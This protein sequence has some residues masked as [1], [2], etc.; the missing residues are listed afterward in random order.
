MYIPHQFR[1]E[2]I[3][4][5]KNFIEQ[6]SFGILISNGSEKIMATHIPFELTKNEKEKDV[7]YS[8]ISRGNPQWKSF[9][10]DAKVL[11]IFSGPNAYISSSWYD[12]ENVPTWNYIAVHVYGTIKIIEGEKLLNSIKRLVDKHEKTSK[13]P[14]SVES[15]SRRLLEQEIKGIIGFE[16]VIEE[17]QAA[18]KLSQNRDA[19]NY[20]KIKEEL[21]TKGDSASLAIAKEM[22]NKNP[23]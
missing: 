10:E 1:N 19:H 20:N 3:S 7:L 9:E 11:I 17:I 18:Y 15:M 16:I 13:N 12:H 4:E 2:N 22:E 21:S 8:H 14:V 6:N 5:I 23:K